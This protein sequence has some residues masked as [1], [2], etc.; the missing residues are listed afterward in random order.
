MKYQWIPITLL[1]MLTACKPEA[2]VNIEKKQ[3]VK[4]EKT[5]KVSPQPPEN[6]K[7]NQYFAEFISESIEQFWEM[8]PGYG[9][10]VG[11][12]KYDDQLPLPDQKNREK[13]DEFAINKLAQ[14]RSFD[15]KKLNSNNASDYKIL[16]NQLESSLW[17]NK[18]FKSHEWDPSDYNVAGGFGL[19]LNTNYKPLD[20]RLR[21]FYKRMKNIPAYYEIAKNTLKVPTLPHTKIAIQ[22][23]KGA[24]GV[25]T[26]A[27]EGKLAKSTLSEE[28][29]QKMKQRA[30]LAVTAI[31]DYVVWLEAKLNDIEKN[32]AKDFRIG[33]ELY[34]EKFKFDIVSD[35]TGEALYQRALQEKDA[36]HQKMI[37]ITEELWPKYF[38]NEAVPTDKLLAVKT[39]I[40][41]LSPK[42]VKPDEFIPEIKKQIPGLEKFVIDNHL[43][44][45]DPEKPLVVRETPKY[46]RGFAGASI[47]APGPYDAKANT[48]YNVTPLDN[49]DDSQKESYLREYNHWIL[50]ILN[51]HEAIPG[52]YAQL[53]HS[54]K[55]PSLLKSLFG[56]GAMVEGWAVYSERMMLEAGFGNNEPEL[57][58]MYYKWNLRV[59]VNTILDYSIQ[60]LGMTEEQAMDMMINE[61]FQQQAEASG[62]W[63]RATLSQVQ[64]TSYFNGFA[65]ILAFREELKKATGKGFDLYDFHN[66][67]LSYGSAPVPMIKQLMREDYIA[68]H[69][70][71]S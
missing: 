58:L 6:T 38:K 44:E 2:T 18:T 24:I 12:Y 71:E 9:I 20:E 25:F 14:L 37:K 61:A 65:E 33:K 7:V 32:G 46:Q 53:V 45:M 16:E 39:L 26:S 36:V 41:H 63:R 5:N 3:S 42:H 54:N 4:S 19:I 67:F 22:Q 1:I 66:Q 43:L 51:I 30:T 60:V 11:F 70:L 13:S 10:Y 35:Y 27:L 28:E 15:I 50:Q 56:N 40:D 64:L 55:S 49:M 57:W 8:N 31:N 68:K 69:T 52:H 48:Y 59:V 21:S 34:E 29:K 17:Y 62:K 47:N 23:N